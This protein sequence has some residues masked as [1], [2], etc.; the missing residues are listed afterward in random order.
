MSKGPDGKVMSAKKR[1]EDLFAKIAGQRADLQQTALGEPLPPVLPERYAPA[2]RSDAHAAFRPKAKVDTPEKLRAELDKARRRMARYQR[3]LAPS[4]PSA[5]LTVPVAA[6]DWRMETEADRRDF[7]AT[8]A[9]A[10]KWQR[11]SLPNYGGT[12]ARIEAEYRTAIE[13]T[14]AM[15]PKG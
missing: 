7:A 13:V 9:G 10:G 14:P 6:F 8:L 12:V 5:R 15:I 11:V 2:A 1:Q 3:I 4:A